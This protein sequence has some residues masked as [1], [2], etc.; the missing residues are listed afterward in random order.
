[1]RQRSTAEASASPQ[2]EKTRHV[3]MGAGAHGAQAAYAT[4]AVFGVRSVGSID[5]VGHPRRPGAAGAGIRKA[6]EAI[7]ETEL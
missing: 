7:P 2:A 3:G 6:Y 1:V 4:H 5:G